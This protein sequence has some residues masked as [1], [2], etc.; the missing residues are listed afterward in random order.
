MRRV[1]LFTFDWSNTSGNHSGMGPYISGRLSNDIDN[2]RAINMHE[3]G[4]LMLKFINLFKVLYYVCWLS[5][6]L[7][8]ND[9]VFLMEYLGRASFHVEL[10]M[11]LKVLRPKAK[12]YGM[13]HLSGKHLLEINKTKKNISRMINYLDRCYV[14][15]SSLASFLENEIGYKN[16]KTIFHYVDNEYYKP[17][18]S[19]KVKQSLDV[20][21]IGNTKRNFDLLKRIVQDMPN[22]HFN[23]CQ[24]KNDYSSYFG[25]FSNVTLYGFLKENELLNLMQNSDVNLSVM[26]DTIGSNVITTALATGMILVVSD[27]GSIRDYC[28][29]D[30]SYLCKNEQDFV[31][32]INYLTNHL[33]EIPEKRR[34]SYNRS[35]LF[36]Y[37]RFRDL[38]KAELLN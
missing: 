23:I 38:F 12:I 22:V 36:S 35:L 24:G 9:V 10:A 17:L 11:L 7:K 15:G 21:C 2:I 28:T 8:K 25:S 6:V 27:V 20:L 29:E 5:I 16:V 4:C 18:D 1:Y 14:L 31:D 34:K 33:D 19:F 30:E 37:S 13:V 26:E 3:Y 32:S